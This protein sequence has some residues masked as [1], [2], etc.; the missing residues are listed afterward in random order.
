MCRNY[1]HRLSVCQPAIFLL[2]LWFGRQE[3]KERRAKQFLN[4]FPKHF[5]QVGLICTAQICV[6][7]SNRY[8]AAPKTRTLSYVRIERKIFLLPPTI[9][10]VL[11][12]CSRFFLSTRTCSLFVLCPNLMD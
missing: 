6:C 1:C 7:R 8:V 3:A 4:G 12:S 2:L 10:V 5:H 9:N 11:Y